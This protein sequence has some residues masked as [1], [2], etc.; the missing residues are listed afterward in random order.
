MDFH[1]NDKTY[2]HLE[3]IDKIVLKYN[4]KIYL[5]KDSRLEKNSF[6]KNLS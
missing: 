4:G 6:N 5:T 1:I 2:F 3:K